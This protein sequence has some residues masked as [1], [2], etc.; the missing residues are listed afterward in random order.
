MRF[1]DGPLEGKEI[2]PNPSGFKMFNFADLGLGLT[3]RYDAST[4]RHINSDPMLGGPF[5][6]YRPDHYDRWEATRRD[7]IR[8][9]VKGRPA[10]RFR[11]GAA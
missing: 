3:H 1:V 9:S 7:R 2:P 4:G 10:G 5:A 8:A 11:R 6:D